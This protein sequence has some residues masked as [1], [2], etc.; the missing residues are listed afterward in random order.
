MTRTDRFGDAAAG[1][2]KYARRDLDRSGHAHS[3]IMLLGCRPL[4]YGSA[5][6]AA[7]L[8]ARTCTRTARGRGISIRSVAEPVIAFASLGPGI[9]VTSRRRG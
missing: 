1:S 3:I 9:W 7:I 4:L 2:V 5:N 8:I 6:V